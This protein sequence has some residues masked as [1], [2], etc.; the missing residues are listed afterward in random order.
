MVGLLSLGIT[1]GLW[2]HEQQTQ[3]RH[4]RDNFDFGLRQAATR[5]E[6]RMAS[7]E[8]MLRGTRGL[9]EA[10]D[11]VAR[12]DFAAYVEALLAG[13]DFAGLRA[14]A[15][16]PLLSADRVEN[17]IASQ[18]MNGAPGYTVSPPGERAWVAP[19]TYIAPATGAMSSLLGSDLLADPARSVAM[20]RARDAGSAIITDQLRS[21]AGPGAEGES[22]FLMFMPVYAKA[23]AVDTVAARRAHL[24]GWVI[25]SFRVAD[26]MSSLYGEE[27][28]GLDV[29]IYD[30][31]EVS[32]RTLMYPSAPAVEPQRPRFE[33]QE[34]VGFAGHT[35]T[36]SVRSRP[37]FEQH[38]SNDS[39]RIILVAGGGLSGLL[40][41]LTWQ[42]ATARERANAAARTMTRQLRDSTERY[43]RIV[44]TANEGIWTV[45]A[46]G[47]TSFVNPKMQQLLGYGADE[48]RGRPWLEF[49]DD[50]D[51]G[52]LEGPGAQQHDIRFRRRDGSE[53]WAMLSTSAITDADG[54]H[55]GVLAMVTDITERK[56]ADANRA[57]LEG[58]LRQSQKMEAIGTLAGGIAHDFNNI[59]AAIL[60]NVNLVQETLGPDHPA[61]ARLAQIATAS[62]RARSLV[63]QIVTF[64]RQQPQ[65]LVVQLLRPLLEETVTLLR[66]TL[67][68]LVELE[69]RFSDEPLAIGAD[70]TQFQQ[71]LMN[72]CTNAW[73]ALKGSTGKIVIGL[74]GAAPDPDAAGDLSNLGPGPFAHIWVGDNGSGMDEATR[75]RA[76]EPFF[77]TK[78]VGQGTGL[79]LSVVHGIVSSHHGAITVFSRPGEGSRFDLYFPLV[80]APP[81]APAA[82]VRAPAPPPGGGQHV[83]YVDD[84]PVMVLMVEGLLQR[85]GYRVTCITDPLE[86]LQR[87]RAGD[88]DFD[89]V[90]SD[91]NMPELSGLDLARE[92]QRLRP[93]LPVIITSG[94]VSDGLRAEVAR[95]GVRY[96][97]QK[98]F[99]LEQLAGLVHQALSEAAQDTASAATRGP[100]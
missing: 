77:T 84:D 47:L 6:Q 28:P 17:H 99:T 43:R 60:G 39:A 67:P 38:Y 35:W 49:M 82:P 34:Y 58:Q 40:A 91:F 4:L 79:G 23:F 55:A 30:G 61:L 31:V 32:D 20:L 50:S 86:A 41:L 44:E 59:L 22:V 3:E 64:S 46:Q 19:V 25:A 74:D 45:D 81:I 63:Q 26:L 68:A 33:T 48:M 98:E 12:E 14:I 52:A 57:V 70:A 2:H 29:R 37:E 5:V 83:L 88:G 10:A 95:A 71:V 75:Q 21:R 93:G 1:A 76:F 73:H 51:R 24:R 18:R 11:N 53:L 94:Y 96:V 69:T 27:T 42:L 15:Y 13:A 65:A 100:Q 72:L 16:A 80:A 78:P 56:L 66:S 9:F 92:I 90:V 36:L 97:M 8:Q 85:W 7:Y 62:D 89:V 87:L 54:R